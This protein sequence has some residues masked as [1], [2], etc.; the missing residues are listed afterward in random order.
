MTERNPLLQSLLS[1]SNSYELIASTMNG[2]LGN[3]RDAVNR[4]EKNYDRITSDRKMGKFTKFQLSNKATVKDKMVF[5]VVSTDLSF[6]NV[7]TV[8]SPRDWFFHAG[9][10]GQD[11]ESKNYFCWM[12][13]SEY[14]EYWRSGYHRKN[15]RLFSKDFNKVQS[16][17]L[18]GIVALYK[19]HANVDIT[20]GL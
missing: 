18:Q 9:E 20:L 7:N 19:E 8:G 1:E 5:F 14:G 17:A 15:K 4:M 11:M 16:T 12:G 13:W 6:L 3:F 10:I 2:Q